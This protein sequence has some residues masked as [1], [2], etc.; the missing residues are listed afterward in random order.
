MW[1]HL[2]LLLTLLP[3]TASRPPS[4]RFIISLRKTD[5]VGAAKD[6][7]RASF[8]YLVWRRVKGERAR[9]RT[10]CR[11]SP[12]R[13]GDAGGEGSERQKAA[14]ERGQEGWAQTWSTPY[15]TGIIPRSPLPP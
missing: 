1:V 11:E 8:M 9:G 6:W 5:G 13:R 2:R 10:S 4:V 14:S 15:C 7:E 12:A 3:A